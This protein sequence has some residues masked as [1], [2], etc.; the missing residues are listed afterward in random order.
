MFIDFERAKHYFRLMHI[1]YLMSTLIWDYG[2]IILDHRYWGQRIACG[3]YF[4]TKLT[5]AHCY[6]RCLR[7]SP[8]VE[9]PFPIPFF[10]LRHSEQCHCT[11]SQFPQLFPLRCDWTLLPTAHLAVL[12]NLS[13]IVDPTLP[14][15]Y[16]PR[17]KSDSPILS[18]QLYLE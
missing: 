5:E 11:A 9:E 1:N 8:K 6:L 3:N 2:F 18:L 14:L 15:G 10:R 12:F 4:S 16:P 13:R 17:D 7:C